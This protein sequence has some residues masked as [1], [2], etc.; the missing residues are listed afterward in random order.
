MQRSVYYANNKSTARTSTSRTH[1]HNR[2]VTEQSFHFN[3]STHWCSVLQPQQVNVTNRSIVLTVNLNG[4][5][6][7]LKTA[8]FRFV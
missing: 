6:G 3:K 5:L 1:A 4:R 2:S 7:L 8:G